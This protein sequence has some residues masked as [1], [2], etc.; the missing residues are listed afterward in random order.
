MDT[1]LAA[2]ALSALTDCLSRLTKLVDPAPYLWEERLC[3]TDCAY[4]TTLF[5]IQDV[6]EALGQSIKLPDKLQAWQSALYRNHIIH[7]VVDDNREAISAWIVSKQK[8]KK[9]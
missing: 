4:P 8:S 2:P 1:N 5:M 9:S 7:R 6:S 3:L